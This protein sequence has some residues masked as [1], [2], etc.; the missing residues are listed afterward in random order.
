MCVPIFDSRTA[1]VLITILLFVAVGAFLYGARRTVIAFLF[2]VFFAYLLDPLVNLVNRTRLGRGSRGR[3]IAIVYLVLICV[4]A[5]VFSLTGPKLV[6]EARTLGTQLPT[7]LENVTSGQIAHQIGSRRGWSQNTQ[8][9]IERFLASHSNEILA[10]ARDIGSRAAALATNVIWIVLI[11]ILAIFFLRDGREIANAIIEVA[12]RR[13]QKQLISGI[14]E[15][16][17]EMLASYIRAQIILAVVSGIAYTVVLTIMRVPY[18][19]VLGLMGGMMEFVPV[20]GPLVAAIC[21]L[22]VA[23]LSNYQ[24]LL[25]VLIFLGVWRLIQ[26]YMIAPRIMGTRVELHPLAA[27]FGI[28]VGGEIAGVVGVYLSIPVIA[29]VRILWRRWQRYEKLQQQNVPVD[30]AELRAT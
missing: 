14:F 3:S 11:P 6:T 21:I 24:H 25:I 19:F 7:L 1:R 8:V 27:L 17:H 23:F 29:T 28:L 22:G 15:D 18:S 2:A 12:E 9:Y 30:P 26:D 20:M 16:L 10:W 5:I 4:L 13:S